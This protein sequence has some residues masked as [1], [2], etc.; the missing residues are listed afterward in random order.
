MIFVISSPYGIIIFLSFWYPYDGLQHQSNFS[1][2]GFQKLNQIYVWSIYRAWVS[3][4]W[5]ENMIHHIVNQPNFRVYKANNQ[6]IKNNG[7]LTNKK[8]LGTKIKVELITFF[9]AYIILLRFQ[10]LLNSSMV[11]LMRCFLTLELR[12]PLE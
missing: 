7:W 3:L 8:G 9:I 6:W 12:T 1:Q 11:N 5:E 4:S 2:L 10:T